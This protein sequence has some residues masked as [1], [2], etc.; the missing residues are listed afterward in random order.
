MGAALFF[1]SSIKA[2]A[3][4]SGPMLLV[5]RLPDKPRDQLRWRIIYQ[6]GLDIV[7]VV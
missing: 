7:R 4:R 2:G 3:I 6:L 5:Q 1:A